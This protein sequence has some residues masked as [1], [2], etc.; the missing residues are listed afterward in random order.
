MSESLPESNASFAADERTE[1]LSLSLAQMEVAAVTDVGMRRSQNEDFFLYHYQLDHLETP[2]GAA[3]TAK[4]FFVLC[5]GMGGH[6]RGEIASLEAARVFKQQVEAS[7]TATGLPSRE[8]LRSAVMTANQ[9]LFELNQTAAALGNDRMG[10]TLVAVLLQGTKVA[11]V[12]VGDSRAYRYSRLTGLD[13]LTRDHEVGQLAIAQ[14]IDPEI[15]YARPEAHQLTQA[16]GPRSNDWI[17]P[18]IRFFEVRE[19]TLFLLCS[20]GLSDFDLLEEIVDTH[21]APLLQVRTSL[22]YGV[23]QLIEAGNEAG[24]HDNLTAVAVRLRLRPQLGSVI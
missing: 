7:W 23:Q 15:A 2:M 4:G 21:V 8:A 5:D 17:D 19:D 20:D 1:M 16:L 24:G 22:Q 14:G 6:A 9:T 12:H 13:Q 3:V 11:I 18:D 10:T